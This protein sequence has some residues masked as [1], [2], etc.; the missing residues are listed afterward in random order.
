MVTNLNEIP[1]GS[2][3]IQ[4]GLWLYTTEKTLAGTTLTLKYL[5]S[6]EGYC[7]Y[8]LTDTYYDEEGNQIPESEVQPSQRIYYQYM[9]LGR[10][11]SQ[12]TIEQINARFVSVL[13]DDSFEIVS[14]PNTSV[15]A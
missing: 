8:D 1:E 2:V 9:A 6:S 4:T 15:V 13:V 12:W 10:N 3:E 14:K 7:F 5:Y 11:V